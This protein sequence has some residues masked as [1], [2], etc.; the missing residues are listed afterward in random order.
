MIDSH[1]HY[2]DAQ[3]ENDRD[4]VIRQAVE[5]GVTHIINAGSDLMSS[6]LSIELS[7]RHREVFAAVGFHPHD[8]SSCSEENLLA[9]EELSREEKVV[10]IGEIGLD[11]HYDFSPR[12]TQKEWFARQIALAAKLRLPIIIHNRESHQDMLDIVKAFRSENITGVFH[13]FS[14]SVEM[15]REL[16]DMGFY[17]GIGG[18]VTF[19]NASR[20]V[21]VVR[22]VPADRL[23]MET[24]CPYLAPEPHRGKRNWSGYL[25]YIIDKIAVIKGIDYN[26]TERITSENARLLFGLDRFSDTA[27]G[28]D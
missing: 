17:I 22:Y 4:D 26:E 5:A 13:C 2:D 19:K 10:A 24:D 16:L 1:A 12:D 25:K 11:Y 20:P 18:P 6:K 23:L 7:K 3:F 28:R 15:A 21:E 14:G 9:I 27:C 8:A